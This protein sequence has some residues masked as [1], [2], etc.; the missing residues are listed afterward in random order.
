MVNTSLKY[1]I[2]IISS[3]LRNDKLIE[4][5]LYI[6]KCEYACY[7][8]HPCLMKN[9]LYISKRRKKKKEKLSIWKHHELAMISRWFLAIEWMAFFLFIVLF[10]F[11]FF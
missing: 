3:I 6:F 1:Q 4:F 11:F 9:S 8:S 5:L 2:N 10:F 7:N